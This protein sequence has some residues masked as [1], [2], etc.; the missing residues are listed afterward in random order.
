MCVYSPST[1]TGTPGAVVDAHLIVSDS[2]SEQHRRLTSQ[3]KSEF[4]RETK[5]LWAPNSSV[6]T[7][8]KNY[9][10]TWTWLL[11]TWGQVL[12]S[13]DN[14]ELLIFC[15]KKRKGSKN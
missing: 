9:V 10:H 3:G 15:V 2:N 11:A 13:Q 5:E 4:L 1:S 14:P 8:T 12:D 6:Q 7:H